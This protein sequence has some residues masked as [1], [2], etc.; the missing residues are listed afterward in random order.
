M[1]AV[2]LYDDLTL[3]RLESGAESQYTINWHDDAPKPSPIDWP[4]EKDLAVRA[5][6]LIESTLNLSLPVKLTLTKRIPVGAG[7]AGGSSDAAAALLSLRDL[8]SL[9]LDN[10]ALAQLA[11]Q[12]GSD[13]AFFL[14]EKGNRTPAPAIVQGIGDQIERTPNI[15]THPDSPALALII[16][17]LTCSTPAVYRAFDECAAHTFDPSR[18]RTLALRAQL[19]STALFNDLA[20]PALRVEPLLV[21]LRTA[22]ETALNQPVHI[23]GSGSCMFVV[24]NNSDAQQTFDTLRSLPELTECAVL[25]V[26]TL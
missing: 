5:H 3:T 4:I 25:S 10:H 16:P 22:I 2:D 24:L 23:T 12:L 17:P 9:D 11:G 15:A 18:A 7:L 19:D 13:I 6:R 14:P 21:P 26:R 20:E 8:F 1:V